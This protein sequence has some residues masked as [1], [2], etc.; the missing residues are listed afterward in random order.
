MMGEK[1][2]SSDTR[3]QRLLAALKDRAPRVTPQR[4]LILEVISGS[5]GHL[6]AD[7][8]VTEVTLRMPT[9]SPSTIYRNL[10]ALEGFGL[11][12][13]IHMG[14]G[15]AQYQAIDHGAH[16]HLVCGTCGGTQ[17]IDRDTIRSLEASL[18]DVHGFKPNLEHFAIYGTCKGCASGPVRSN[19]LGG[20]S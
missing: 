12:S 15:P 4:R 19:P 1:P 7:A 5:D 6:S 18:L 3:S 20:E 10:Q 16:L 8:I 11:I 2:V 9:V 13:H 17:E 14:H